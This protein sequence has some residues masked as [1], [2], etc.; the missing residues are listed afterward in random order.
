MAPSASHS[1]GWL[2]ALLFFAAAAFSDAGCDKGLGPIYE[3]TGFE[4][5]I[6]Y[7]NWPGIEKVW[8]LRLIAF[9]NVP[10]DSSTL[11]SL[12]FSAVQNPG[13]IVMYPP[14]GTPGLAKLVDSTHYKL[15]TK[16]STLLEL[17]YNYI[18]LAWRY[19]P[20]SLTDWT[21]AGVYTFDPDNFTPAP[22]VVRNR[23]LLENI[24]IYADFNKLPPKPWR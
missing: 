17:K 5:V 11:V 12:L 24:N 20:N 22:V 10:T 9:E 6:Y 8:E 3:E 4:G 7:S 2:L 18:V 19:G 21:P 23:R 13:H 1:N 16:V 15:T 14:L